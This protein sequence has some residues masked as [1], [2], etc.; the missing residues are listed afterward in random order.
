VFTFNPDSTEPDLIKYGDIQPVN[1]PQFIDVRSPS[2]YKTGHIPGAVN[3]PLFSDSERAI[4]GTLYKKVSKEVAIAKGFELAKPKR[5][6]IIDEVRK[7]AVNEA[8]IYCW[9]GGM[10]SGSVCRLLIEHGIQIK[11]IEDGYKGY[12]KHIRDSFLKP[13]HFIVLG[14]NT[15]SGKTIILH[16]LDRQNIQT[17]DLE[18]LANHKG[19]VFGHINQP[20]QPTTEQFENNLYQKFQ[21]LNKTAPIIIENESYAIGQVHLPEPVLLQMRSAPLIS[22]NVSKEARVKRLVKEYGNCNK[23][24][25]IAAAKQLEKKLGSKK[26]A[27]IE[28]FLQH[29]RFDLACDVLLTHY[30]SY[31]NRSFGKRDK[32]DVYVLQLTGTDLEKDIQDVARKIME[33]G[34]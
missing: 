27:I 2:E 3:V 34:H 7:I 28:E 23:N 11:K 18:G 13:A 30:D 33:L 31:Y 6:Q 1:H 17:L 16:G 29:D 24:E 25:L 26:L 9:R 32:E 14:G 21:P 15:G 4:V 22:M 20:P 10:R 19:S 5:Q 8:I 12:R